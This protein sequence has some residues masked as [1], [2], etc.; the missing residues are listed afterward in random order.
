MIYLRFGDAWYFLKTLLIANPDDD[1]PPTP[2]NLP[3]TASPSEKTVSDMA[4]V[5]AQDTRTRS[6]QHYS[7][8]A[9]RM[10]EQGRSARGRTR[11]DPRALLRWQVQLPSG[12]MHVYE[13]LR[14]MLL[15]HRRCRILTRGELM[16]A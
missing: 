15:G 13:R 3:R 12:R 11:R 7:I 10:G 2:R 4:S 8:C 5:V 9:D 6:P 14:W 1:D 16:T